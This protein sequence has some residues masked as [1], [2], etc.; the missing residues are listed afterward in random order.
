MVADALVYQIERIDESTQT[1]SPRLR[2]RY[3]RHAG[4]SRHPVA[5]SLIA[6]RV[7]FAAPLFTAAKIIDGWEGSSWLSR[8]TYSPWLVANLH[9]TQQP[10]GYERYVYPIAAFSMIF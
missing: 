8:F 3:L 7:I 9:L 6:G 5:A 1:S 10:D 2:V 4:G